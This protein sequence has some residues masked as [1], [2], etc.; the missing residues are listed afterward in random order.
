MAA[1]LGSN[2]GV[3]AG[4]MLGIFVVAGLMGWA[5]ARVMLWEKAR[6]W[7]QGVAGALALGGGLL[8]AF[9]ASGGFAAAFVVGLAMLLS[10][11]VQG[12]P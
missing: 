4:A 5:T 11:M 1:F 3:L 8:L 9:L 10:R 6:H 12:Q 2:P 7:E